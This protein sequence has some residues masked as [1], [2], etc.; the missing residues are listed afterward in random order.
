MPTLAYYAVN[1]TEK[2]WPVT[3]DYGNGHKPE[4]NVKFWTL[5]LHEPTCRFAKKDR[6][7]NPYKAYLGDGG[8]YR[9][10]EHGFNPPTHTR[11]GAVWQG[12][13]TC[14]TAN[15]DANELGREALETEKRANAIRS[16]QYRVR[17]AIDSAVTARNQAITAARN[18]WLAQHADELQAYEAKAAAEWAAG[19]PE[20]AALIQ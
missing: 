19:N 17:H 13:K 18:F 8:L 9:L 11:I 3:I 2:Y 6:D 15:L 14:G 4:R 20:Q 1:G 12:C 16:E 10:A 5:T 7:G